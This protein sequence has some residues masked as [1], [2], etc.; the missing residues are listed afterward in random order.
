VLEAHAWVFMLEPMAVYVSTSLEQVG[1]ASVK[2]ELGETD[3]VEAPPKQYKE[4]VITVASARLDAMVAAIYAI[5]RPQA[6]QA[7]NRELVKVNHLPV[8]RTDAHL[9]QGDL[10]SLKGHGRAVIAEVGRSTKSGRERYI[11]HKLT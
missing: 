11:I 7:I 8:H 10:I 1:R 9:A 4:L 2:V 3:E 6:V 5:S